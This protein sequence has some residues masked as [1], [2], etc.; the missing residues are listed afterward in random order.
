MS[1]L[2]IKRLR[3]Q[4]MWQRAKGTKRDNG[5]PYH[6]HVPDCD[7]CQAADALEAA[8]KRI[9]ELEQVLEIIADTSSSVD[10]RDIA[11]DALNR[12]MGNDD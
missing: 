2:K 8:D 9:A 7:I 12:I 5:Y 11:E 4:C 6:K 10:T 1:D 3:R